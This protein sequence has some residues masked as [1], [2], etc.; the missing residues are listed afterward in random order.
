MVFA[1]GFGRSMGKVRLILGISTPDFTSIGVA[2]A[3]LGV[4]PVQ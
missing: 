4:S 2:T 1:G 3:G